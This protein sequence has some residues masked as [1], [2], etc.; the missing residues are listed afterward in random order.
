MALTIN[1]NLSSIIAQSSLK[2]STSSLNQA[3]ERM[4]TGFKINHAKDNAAGYFIKTNLSTKI[5][6]YSVAEDNALKALDMFNT[7]SDSLSIMQ[8]M[9]SKLRIIAVN[10]VNKTNSLES[11]N[12]LNLEAMNIINELY[13]VKEGTLY[14]GMSLLESISNIPTGAGANLDSL[15]IKEEGFINEI[16]KVDTSIMTRLEDVADDTV[17]SSGN[18][19][20]SSADELVK[21]SKMS[22]N[23]QIKGGTFVLANDID[24]SKYSIGEGFEPIAKSGSFKGSINGNG[25]VIKNLYINRPNEDNVA[26][27]GGAHNPV[28]NL[29]LENVE[30]IGRTYVGGIVGNAQM[31]NL[32]NC[33]VKGGTLKSTSSNLGGLAGTLNYTLVDSCWTDVEV[34]GNQQVGGLVGSSAVTIKNCYV[35]G[36]VYG[37]DNVGGIA[38]DSWFTTLNCYVDGNVSG[39]GKNIGGLLGLLSNSYASMSNCTF[40]GSVSGG[41]NLGVV[42][43]NL[44]NSTISNVLYNGGDNKNVAEIGIGENT[45]KVSSILGIILEKITSIQVGINSNE[46]SVITVALGINDISLIDSVYGCIENE[47]SIA[48]IDGLL[49]LLSNRQTEIGS[50]Q[51]R[52][53]SVIEEVGIQREN[54]LSTRSMIS[55][56]DI[57]EESSAYIRNQIL[58]QASA[59]LLATANQNPSIALQLL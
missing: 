50:V 26:L 35:L 52:L 49:T 16:N 30:I 51:N 34:I 36:N 41:S 40:Y 54:L 57:A 37:K 15:N 28:Y 3:I 59:T 45:G 32:E 12:A 42:V 58:Q 21:L 13:R 55:D 5:N 27:I 2:S 25:Y 10:A 7:A 22:N 19:S 18:Y 33:Y 23:S 46:N 44:Q 29:G 14:N 39:T 43:G 48:I 6:A 8:T 53:L 1:T 47:N 31:N 56:A 4:S 20:I 11:L 9:A 38:G 24:M 17:I